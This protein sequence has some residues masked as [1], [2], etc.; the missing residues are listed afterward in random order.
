MFFEKGGGTQ[1]GIRIH[2]AF[3]QQGPRKE[4]A[5]GRFRIDPG[6][7]L[8]PQIN[9]PLD[10][11]IL[12]D[13]DN[14]AIGLAAQTDWFDQWYQRI[15]LLALDV[16]EGGQPGNIHLVGL[17][18]FQQTIVVGGQHQPNFLDPQLLLEV[19]QQSLMVEHHLG[20]IDIGHPSQAQYQ[21]RP[22]D[23]G[24]DSSFARQNHH[25]QHHQATTD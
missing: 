24:A 14:T 2:P 7:T 15:L 22:G 25:Q 10:A 6:D 20:G 5:R 3:G 16:A 13:E 1:L 4:V 8:A 21:L 23:F 11:G 19:L 12:T 17:K 18:L 9:Q